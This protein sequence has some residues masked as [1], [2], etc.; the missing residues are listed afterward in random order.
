MRFVSAVCL[1]I[2]TAFCTSAQARSITFYSDG[3]MVEMDLA[4]TKGI[5]EIALP[6][7]MTEGTL[8]IRPDSGTSIQ[9]VDIVPAQTGKENGEKDVDTLQ[10]QKNR[11][12]DRL[13]ALATREAIFTS[14]AKSQSGKAPRKSKTNPD[15]MQSIRQGTEFAIA[16]LEAVYTS[17]RKTEQEIRRLDA[18]IAAAKG[19]R[20]GSETVARVTISPAKGKVTASY[21]LAQQGWAPRY[22]IRLDG[23][24]T[25]AVQLFGELPGSFT[26]FLLKASPGRLSDD[27]AAALFPIQSGQVAKLANF[28]LPI[29]EEF[30]KAGVQ[31]SFSCSLN[32]TTQTNLP[33]GDASIYRKGEYVGTF[34]FE[35]ISSGRVKKISMGTN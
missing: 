30:F 26:G 17:R 28:R 16:Q 11:L 15:P 25:A 19:T 7:T 29:T 5:V 2:A 6:S 27:P 32:N 22:D 23:D 3:A 13:Q 14:A 10:E 20:R 18:R 12:N 4:A 8:R 31:T 35:G 21:A 9:R 33:A 34:R 1:V 24:G